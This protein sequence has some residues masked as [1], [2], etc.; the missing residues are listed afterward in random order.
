MKLY[1]YQRNSAGER[2]RIALGLKGLAYEYVS[3]PGLAEGE[4]RRINP[5]GLMPALELDNGQVIAQS[6]AILAF[7][8]ERFPEPPLLP[9]D[10]VLRAQS[11]SFG[12]FIAAE[13]HAVTVS[14]VRRFVADELGAG[15][16]GEALW[17]A[18]WTAEGLARLEAMLAQRSQDFTFCYG[19]TPGWADLHLIPALRNARR[20]DVALA[21]Y[22]R[23]LA[24]EGAC[25]E[26][27]AFQAARPEAQP[28]F[29]S[30]DLSSRA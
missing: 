14:R 13:M 25:A 27:P 20:F 26:I 24:V 29:I 10:P 3:V 15:P 1:T 5:Q 2:V 28:D 8:E 18:H 19:E 30:S 17:L 11:R 22:E 21:S 4:Y 16:E 12:L 7:L 6:G 23:L 9:A